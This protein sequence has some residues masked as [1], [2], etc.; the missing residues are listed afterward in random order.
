VSFRLWSFRFQPGDDPYMS[1]PGRLPPGRCCYILPAHVILGKR[2][3]NM[4]EKVGVDFGITIRSIERSLLVPAVSINFP[5]NNSM[6]VWRRFH[7]D[8]SKF[9][10]IDLRTRA[11]DDCESKRG[12][13]VLICLDRAT[14]PDV[15][16]HMINFNGK[17]AQWM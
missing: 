12:V 9:Y 1:F 17:C 15:G 16:K 10:R 7:T 14:F 6:I 4:L 5:R 3:R 8:A 13:V 11:L 2:I